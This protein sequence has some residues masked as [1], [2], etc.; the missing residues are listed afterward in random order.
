VIES[1]KE[2][3]MEAG[4]GGKF[5]SETSKKFVQ[6]V[7]ISM[8]GA[9]SRASDDL[10]LSNPINTLIAT[11]GQRYEPADTQLPHKPQKNRDFT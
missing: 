2:F 5:S 11:F 8:R 4:N 3:V 10:A 1:K 7:K 9:L 6:V